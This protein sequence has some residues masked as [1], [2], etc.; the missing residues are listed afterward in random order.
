MLEDG[1]VGDGATVVCLGEA[2]VSATFKSV[3]GG[4]G[5]G[6]YL[7]IASVKLYRLGG[8]RDGETIGL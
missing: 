6:E 2:R 1:G 7:D 8:V 5:G 3:G 4:G